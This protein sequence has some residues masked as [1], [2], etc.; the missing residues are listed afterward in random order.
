MAQA[1]PKLPI[2]GLRLSQ[3]LGLHVCATPISP[4]QCLPAPPS[5]IETGRVR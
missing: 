1:H 3:L 5:M 2:R 4:A